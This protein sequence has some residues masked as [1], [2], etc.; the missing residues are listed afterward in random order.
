MR[1]VVHEGLIKG[2][3]V[4]ALKQHELQVDLDL[5]A[6]LNPATPKLAQNVLSG[7]MHSTPKGDREPGGVQ[8]RAGTQGEVRQDLNL[9]IRKLELEMEIERERVRVRE[10][11]IES[12]RERERE[13]LEHERMREREVRV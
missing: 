7:F 4:E 13:R 6:G 1:G 3:M 2:Q 12:E 8:G 10:R 11:E 9:Q 5:R